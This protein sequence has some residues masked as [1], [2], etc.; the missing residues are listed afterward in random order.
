MHTKI[1]R[2]MFANLVKEFGLGNRKVIWQPSDLFD[3][4]SYMDAYWFLE[5]LEMQ[6]M[7]KI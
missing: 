1:E 5:Q 4:D 3:L 6:L 2:G 7:K